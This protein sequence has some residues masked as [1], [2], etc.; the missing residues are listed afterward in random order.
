MTRSGTVVGNWKNANSR[1]SG[2]GR[3]LLYCPRQIRL[4]PVIESQELCLAEVGERRLVHVLGRDGRGE[5]GHVAGHRIAQ[6][7]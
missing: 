1:A 3:P 7:R 6:R 2:L 4:T 5:F